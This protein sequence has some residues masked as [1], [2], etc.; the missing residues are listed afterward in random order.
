MTF[1]ACQTHLQICKN[2]K[3]YDSKQV[4]QPIECIFFGI[5]RSIGARFQTIKMG[6]HALTSPILD[7]TQFPAVSMR[8]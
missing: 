2:I 6:N 4:Y 1:R 5:T 8:V 3:I 7:L